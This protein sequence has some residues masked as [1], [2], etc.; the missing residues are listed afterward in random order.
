[1][2]NGWRVTNGREDGLRDVSLYPPTEPL[3]DA[4]PREPYRTFT[5]G[6]GREW[7]VWRLAEN[8]VE[9]LRETS[10]ARRA[11]LIFLG[12]A[13][14]TRRYAPVPEKWRRMKDEQ[15]GALASQAKPFTPR[16][17]R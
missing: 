17:P 8:Y 9:E 13:G 12:P 4:T 14:E 5:D 10:S 7:M 11:W 1:M 15:L 2:V 3:L 6:E 16:A